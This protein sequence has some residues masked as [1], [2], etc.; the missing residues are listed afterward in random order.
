MTDVDDLRVAL[1]ARPAE[2]WP[3][4]DVQQIM[5]AGGRIR[6]RR[7][8]RTGVISVGAVSAFL[9]AGVT[10][11]HGGNKAQVEIAAV[12]N[13]VP[14]PAAA[15]TAV[16]V[17]SIRIAS[18][19]ASQPK[20]SNGHSPTEMPSASAPT[21]LPPQD[22]SVG[23]VISTGYDQDR[24]QV[25]YMVSF[26][27][28]KFSGVSLA[29]VSGQAQRGRLVGQVRVNP[30]GP[31]KSPGF[32]VFHRAPSGTQ[33]MPSFGYYLGPATS[34]YAT[35]RLNRSVVAKQAQWSKNPDVVVFWFNPG[36]LDSA[37]GLKTLTA[38]NSDGSRIS[39]AWANLGKATS[40]SNQ[41]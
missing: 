19:A 40:F 34:I 30:D 8:V 31:S 15:P 25:L 18:T 16:P 28:P 41:L 9:V 24:S 12:P 6:R 13:T 1:Q 37:Q 33:M 5:V 7:R 27:D 4:L 20:S 38:Q 17:P 22:R 11:G 29:L 10:I 3:E 35:D 36:D 23:T 14:T 32:C 21:P 26:H 39:V 2:P